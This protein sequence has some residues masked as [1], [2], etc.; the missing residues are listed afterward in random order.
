MNPNHKIS[1]AIADD[2]AMLR[3]GLIKL[4]SLAG[5]FDCLFDVQN[6]NEV[7]EQ[8][9]SH[10]IPD[11]LI[12]DINM[13]VLNG[14]DTALWVTKHYPQ[15]KILA[16]SMFDDEAAIIKMIHSGARGYITKH[17]EP[18][19]LAEAITTLYQKGSYLPE[20]LSG[21]IL[22]GIKNNLLVLEESKPILTDREKEF[23][24]LLCQ[25]LSYAEIAMKMY[26]SPQTI[27][28]YRKKLT[29]KL[30]VKGKSGLI[31]YAMNNGL[32]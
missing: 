22:N 4:L 6:G 10:K 16:L 24:L 15:V 18:E 13:S 2:H 11:V 5:N 8:L 21:K 12:L 3:K 9:R 32:N 28:D 30:G 25:E 23:L 14:H 7:I 1:F 27:H 19:K 17:A 26:L 29:V 31:I 20:S